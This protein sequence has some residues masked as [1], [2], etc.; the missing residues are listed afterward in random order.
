LAI[1]LHLHT[2]ASDGTWTPA[3]L[4]RKV[5]EADLTAFAVT[6]H[7]VTA[8]LAETARLVAGTGLTF[9]PGV[10]ISASY[11][12][13]IT[14]HIIG[15]NINPDHPALKKVLAFNMA[16]W[17]KSEWDSIANLAKLGIHVDPE[18]Y[19]YWVS[20]RHLG[21]WPLLNALQEAGHVQGFDDYFGK[22][23]GKGKPAYVDIIFAQPAE[24]VA[25]IRQAGGVPVLAHPALYRQDGAYLYRNPEFQKEMLAWGIEGLEAFSSSHTP[26]ES[27]ELVQLAEKLGLLITGGSDC[28]G[29]FVGR[30]LGQPLVADRYLQPLLARMQ[31]VRM[32]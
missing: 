26:E 14:L 7:D 11:T 10:E 6:D 30:R 23:F 19:R 3:E 9:I 31:E 12:P 2:Q 32:I 27:A 17:E 13:D 5:Q 1:D 16:A 24:V 4:V 22:Y 20:A 18:R 28:H 29:D 15:Y 25:A 8:A 21:G